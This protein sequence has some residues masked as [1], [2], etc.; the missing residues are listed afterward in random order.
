[1]TSLVKVIDDV[2][3]PFLEKSHDLLVLDTKNIMDAS[4]VETVTNIKSLGLEQHKKFVKERLQQ[5]LKSTT[6]TLSKNNL[7][8]FSRPTIKFPSKDKLQLAALKK[9]RDLRLY[10][11]C[12]TMGGDLD[13]FFSHEIQAVPLALSCGGKQRIGTKAD[14]LHC[15]ESC[16]ASKPQ[17]A[18]VDAI[19][20]DGAV[21]VHMLHP[22][23]AKK[24]QEYANFVLDH[25]YP[26]R[27]TKLAVLMWSEMC[28]YQTASKGQLDKREERVS[29]D[30]CPL[31]LRYPRAGKTFSVLVTIR[32]SYSN[33]LPNMSPV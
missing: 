5:S 22:G 26:P 27:L 25:I 28:I 8:L 14:L 16:V 3:N 31:L 33:S 13:Q 19:I 18:Q 29:E 15:F 32:Q 30:V 9:D 7:F 2:G 11:A 23:T 1:M 17:N 24:F 12:Q 6:E 20:L 4:V 10:I 21:V